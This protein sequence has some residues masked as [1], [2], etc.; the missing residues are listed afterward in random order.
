VP[1]FL[2]PYSVMYF[3][4]VTRKSAVRT[5][6]SKTTLLLL[7]RMENRGSQGKLD[8]LAGSPISVQGEPKFETT[9][10]KKPLAMVE[11]EEQIHGE[12]RGYAYSAY[13]AAAGGPFICFF[14]LFTIFLN[15]GTNAFAS[16]WLALWIRQ[17]VCYSTK[18]NQKLKFQPATLF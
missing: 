14:Y 18:K 17:G 8:N 4:A 11:K 3:H 9:P 12:V 5:S 10:S 1:R 6:F 7:F 15:T 13:M 2:I 16:Y